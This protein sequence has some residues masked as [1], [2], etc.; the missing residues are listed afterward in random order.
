MNTIPTSQQ[1]I[2]QAP[3]QI[4]A[5]DP[6]KTEDHAGTAGRTAG[7]E[8]AD[9]GDKVTLAGTLTEKAKNVL[10]AIDRWTSPQE[11]T[12]GNFEKPSYL[13]AASASASAGFSMAGLPGML[14]GVVSTTLGIFTEIKMDSTLKGVIAGAAASAAMGAALGAAGVMGGV[15]KGLI[16]GGLMG[17]FQVFRGS[18]NSKVRDAAGNT[19]MLSA[20]FISGPSKITAGLGA[21]VSERWVETDKTW[22]KSLVSGATAAAFGAGLCAIGLSPVGLGTA[23]AV[24]AAAGAL[25][26]IVG[27]RFSQ[28]FRNLS[29]KMGDAAD[30]AGRKL[31]VIKKP[32]TEKSKNLVGAM[33]SSFMKE[34]LRTFALSDGSVGAIALAGLLE[35]LETLHIFLFAKGDKEKAGEKK[36]E[37]AAPKAPTIPESP[38]GAKVGKVKAESA[39]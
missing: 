36:A 39:L 29:N 11:T 18:A 7:T 6:E 13:Q 20:P 16:V 24:N 33:P 38:A 1:G 37:T 19:C 34:G 35:T 22:L 31:G 4:R 30:K 26:P 9:Q 10:K 27:P 25:G 5:G 17:G 21:A 23:V 15:T 3:L 2:S 12:G 28:F 14:T 32:L 8:Q